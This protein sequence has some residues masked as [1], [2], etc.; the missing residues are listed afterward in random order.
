MNFLSELREGLLIAW[1][2]L[3][4]N[5]LRSALT[6]LG[7]VIGIVTV[8]LMGTALAGLNAAFL[9]SISAIGTDVLYVSPWQWFSDE[10]WWKRR[11]RRLIYLAD[12]R[13]LVRELTCARATA[14]DIRMN[15]FEADFIGVRYAGPFTSSAQTV[16][17]APFCAALGWKEGTASFSSL[18]RFDD[19]IG[20]PL[21]LLDVLEREIASTCRAT[22]STASWN[23]ASAP[24]WSGR[25]RRG[26][27]T[28]S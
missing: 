22:S 9:N 19:V 14:I 24:T 18:R 15:P 10:P 28:F 5:K 1:D 3:R 7:I 8:T 26:R 4:A 13:A 16:M 17:S 23:P 11:N 21:P 27:S 2:S 6:T 12:A 20:D 25:R